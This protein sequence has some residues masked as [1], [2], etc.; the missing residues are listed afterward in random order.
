MILTENLNPIVLDLNLHS[1]ENLQQFID[2][3]K[4]D[5]QNTPVT[6]KIVY[7]KEDRRSIEFTPD[8]I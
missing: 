3:C 4:D 1:F 7:D 2:H 8:D 5:I 6:L